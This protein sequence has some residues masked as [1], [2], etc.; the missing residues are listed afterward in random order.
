MRPQIGLILLFKK[1]VL[2]RDAS[3]DGGDGI[4]RHPEQHCNARQNPNQKFP[5]SHSLSCPNVLH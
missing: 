4:R 2:L 3:L 1:R 5:F